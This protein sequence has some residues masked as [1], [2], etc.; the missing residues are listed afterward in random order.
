MPGME[1]HQ[2]VQ[3]TRN[4]S[5]TASLVLWCAIYGVLGCA[6]G[7]LMGLGIYVAS[8]QSGGCAYSNRYCGRK[9]PDAC[10]MSAMPQHHWV[11]PV[12]HA[13]FVGLCTAYHLRV[14]G[15]NIPD[16]CS[17]LGVDAAAHAYCCKGWC[18]QWRQEELICALEHLGVGYM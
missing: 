16:F 8:G 7:F 13:G 14:G 6:D 10:M 4:V 1:R 18:C 12:M 15:Y 17:P 9:N 2:Q 3:N 5:Q 11:P